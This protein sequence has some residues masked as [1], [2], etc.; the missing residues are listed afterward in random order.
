MHCSRPK[1]AEHNTGGSSFDPTK[2]VNKRS[3]VPTCEHLARQRLGQVKQALTQH[4]NFP[5]NIER[6]TCGSMPRARMVETHAER[7]HDSTSISS[8]TA[9]TPRQRGHD[10]TSISSISRHAEASISSI[11]GGLFFLWTSKKPL[12]QKDRNLAQNKPLW[13]RGFAQ[14]QMRDSRKNPRILAHPPPRT[15]RPDN[16]KLTL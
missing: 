8:I 16:P 10:T 11:R 2:H 12:T 6:Q 13:Q 14:L 5:P 9:D 1:I 15:P 7:G 3:F 4:T